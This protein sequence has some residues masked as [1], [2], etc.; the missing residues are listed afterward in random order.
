MTGTEL[1]AARRRLLLTQTHLADLLDV[2]R[3]T[4]SYYETG[5]A[6]VPRTVELAMEA[7]LARPPTEQRA[8][9]FL[10]AGSEISVARV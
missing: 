10:N 6:K 5:H 2:S 3:P 4:V 7:L 8:Q 9:Q 1:R